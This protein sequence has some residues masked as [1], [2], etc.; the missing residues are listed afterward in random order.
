MESTLLPC[1]AAPKIPEIPHRPPQKLKT[2]PGK[3]VPYVTDYQLHHLCVNG[4]LREAITAL[5]TISQCGSKVNPGTLSRLID[6]CVDSQSIHLGRK[7]H[8]CIEYVLEDA[9]PF[10][11]TKLIG[12]YAK[13]G[14][15]TDAYKV[16]DGM[17]SRDLFTW[18]AMIGACFRESRWIEVVEL[19]Y[20]MMR[21][22]VVP[23]GFLFP[24]ILKACGKC[25]DVETGRLIHSIVLRLGM[26]MEIRVNNSILAVYA[27]HG[28][29]DSAKRVFDYMEIRDIVSWNSILLGYCQRGEIGEVQRLFGLMQTEGFEPTV[30][31]WNILMSSYNQL[32]MCDAAME[33]MREME[34][35]GTIPD[36][37][38]WSCMISGLAQ[39][40]RS[41]EA[42][43]L[44]QEM[45]LSGIEPNEVSLVIAISACA[46]LKSIRKGKEL[47]SIAVKLGF[48][49]NVV[50][51]NSLINMYS[52]CVELEVARKVF[53]MITEKD[54]WSWNSMIGGYCQAG[55]SG[56]AYDLFVR[57]QDSGVPPNVITWNVM[58]NGYMQSGDEDQALDLFLAMEK[59]GSIQQDIA[60][61]NG[62]ITGYVQNGKID[63]AL[64]IFRKMLL[65]HV[66]P[67]PIT[68]LSLLPACANIIAAK[69]V[70]E[71][72]CFALRNFFTSHLSISNALIDAYSKSASINFAKAIFNG[73]QAKDIIS[74]NTMI[75][76]YVL[77]GCSKDAIELFDQ[78]R[79][80]GF[81]PDRITFASLLS[82]YG[83]AKMVDEGK[84][85]FSN[86]I[87]EYE[88]NPGLHHSVAMINLFGR[89]GMLE[90]AMEFIESM[91]IKPDVSIWDALLTASRIHGNVRLAIHAVERLLELDPG[92]VV[93]HHLGL[94]LYALCCI[95][96][97]ALNR[98]WHVKGSLAEA[99]LGWSCTI[100][101]D[102]VH[103][104]DM[105][106][107]SQLQAEIL[108]CL[109]KNNAWKTTR[110][111]P[112]KGLCIMEEEKEDTGWVHSEKLAL[113]YNLINFPQSSDAIRIVKNL[114]ICGDCHSMAKFISKTHGREIYLDDSK[115]LHHIKDGYCS[116]RDYW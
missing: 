108:Q 86:M 99:S 63:E 110:S 9:I 34:S 16:F 62:L 13:C 5:D 35:Y 101:K 68:V 11:E 111:Y 55:Y 85:I 93:I 79:Q 51:G 40:N 21:D 2:P 4:R 75:A 45:V 67:N 71:I 91:A 26:D 56:K 14:S 23:D 32:G 19:F 46:S 49:E 59:D 64:G 95:S 88:I 80:E 66:K 25:G 58:I 116:C 3:T 69:K 94:Q 115:C 96:E 33:M 24:K 92:N 31:T 73:M 76:G 43:E 42:S 102:T 70:K 100:D 78:M 89:S 7:L 27:K 48:D 107:K 18:S 38:S 87:G 8:S 54:V 112:C 77:H 65:S 36:V 103:T 10:I 74:W 39:N 29:L 72:H 84:H 47:H 113:A 52:K 37:F 105:C 12:M 98:K 114:R 106:H 90:E 20:S 104:F 81:K 97:D 61:W 83:L 60:S 22:G 57:M 82:S 44:F 41:N 50:V 109:T 1:K 15:I 28:R 6:A 30:I 17:R 53:D